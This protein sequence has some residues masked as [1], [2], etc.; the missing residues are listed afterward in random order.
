MPSKIITICNQKGGTGKTT[1]CMQIAGSLGL[2]GHRILVVDADRQGT[3]TRWAS[4]ASEDRP[5]PAALSGLSAAGEKVHREVRKF[6]NDYDFIFVDC[7]PASES[8]ITQSALMIS[9][10]ALVPVIP[11]P[12]DLWASVGIRQVIHT[13]ADFNESLKAKLIINQLQLNTSMAV[14]VLE[15]LPEFG[16]EQMKAQVKQRTVYRKSAAFGATVHLFGGRA[17]PAIDEIDA[18]VDETISLLS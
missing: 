5:F 13:I 17:K 12:P 1:L 15:I 10:L 2:R 8:H 7:P 11:S 3:A 4:A 18:L 14:Q 16:I 9:D 6:V